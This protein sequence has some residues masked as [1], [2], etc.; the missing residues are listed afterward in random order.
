[1]L[2]MGDMVQKIGYNGFTTYQYKV[3]GV[4]LNNGLKHIW[5]NSDLLNMV[6]WVRGT[7]RII[8]VYLVHYPELDDDTFLVFGNSCSNSVQLI[9]EIN[10]PEID[11]QLGFHNNRVEVEEGHFARVEDG[12]GHVL[13]AGA[14]A[15]AR[16]EGHATGVGMEWPRQVFEKEMQGGGNEDVL[17]GD[18]GEGQMQRDGGYIHSDNETTDLEDFEDSEYDDGEEDDLLYEANIDKNVEWGGFHER[19]KGN[20]VD[21]FN[22]TIDGLNWDENDVESDEL[23]SLEGSS[24]EDG[25]PKRDK[26]PEFNKHTNMVDPQF[27]VGMVFPSSKV[28]KQ[29][30]KEHAIKTGKDIKF[31]KNDK[32]RVRAGCKPPC[33]WMI[34]AS[35]MHGQMNLQVKTYVPTHNC[36]RMF[37][38]KNV[39]ST[40]LSKKYMES[41]KSNPTWP[42]Q[43]FKQSVQKDH[44]VGV[45]RSQLYRAKRKAQQ[46]I[47]G[48]YKE[49]Y[50]KLWD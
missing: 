23:I 7:T 25:G 10:E 12:E 16:V 50:A 26:F 17:E 20:N 3:P 37:Y 18:L 2:D 35:K 5:N 24:N 38:N 11:L 21:D 29:A 30:V 46:L 45:S 39:N 33:Q 6:E 27:Q 4:D 42:I 31:L 41:I 28:F 44:N 19:G 8:E 22:A 36:G 15:R 40:W 13:R 48:N 1:M 43:S 34:Y 47:E 32:D 9:E 49:Q 14:R